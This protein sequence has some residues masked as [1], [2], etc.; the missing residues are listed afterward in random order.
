M[1]LPETEAERLVR[2]VRAWMQ[3]NADAGRAEAARRYFKEDIRLYGLP[4]G[5]NRR[6]AAEVYKQI[7]TAGGLALALDAGDLL[8]AS[9][10][11]EEAAF[12]EELLRR[13]HRQFDRAA[14][15]RFEAW[16]D[17]VNN[18]AS[19]DGLSTHLLGPYLEAHRPPVREL[20]QWA[21]SSN[22]WR[23]RAA[24]VSLVGSAR[25]GLHL[26]A[27]FRVANLLLPVRDEMVE[28]GVGWVL[29]EATKP[30]GQ[31]EAVVAYLV[32]NRNVASRLTLRYACEKLPAAKK[33]RILG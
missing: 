25:H 4:S 21:K 33:K 19:C 6:R 2:E 24:A 29:K 18:W 11:M 8:Y 16:I 32:R 3:A 14:F 9:G 13:F 27:V 5:L 31:T 12:A 23:Q 7:K 17:C 28:K 15:E 30:R 10:D 22:R 26:P 1:N 20:A